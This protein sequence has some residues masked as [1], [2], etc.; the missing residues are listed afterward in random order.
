MTS[1]WAQPTQGCCSATSGLLALLRRLFD[2]DHAVTASR[3]YLGAGTA[4]GA[5]SP[6]CGKPVRTLVDAGLYLGPPQ[7]LTESAPEPGHLPRPDLL[8][9]TAAAQHH[10]RLGGTGVVAAETPPGERELV[11]ATHIHN[12]PAG[13]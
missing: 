1:G 9:R 6:H 11:E 13:R 10:R 2:E 4:T 8:E 5:G 3:S 7:E 12:K